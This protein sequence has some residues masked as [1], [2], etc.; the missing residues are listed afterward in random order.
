MPFTNFNQQ[1]HLVITQ[2]VMTRG[3]AP[4]ATTGDGF[5]TA[6]MVRYFAG[7]YAPAGDA[8]AQGQILTIAGNESLFAAIGTTY[9]GDGVTTFS[10]LN[11]RQWG[12]LDLGG[13]TVGFNAFNGSGVVT[14][15]AAGA[16]QRY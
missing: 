3:P 15:G 14:N 16:A 13:N 9:G 6:G 11:L 10:S 12:V 8:R 1:G 5:M 4:S 2:Y 7:N